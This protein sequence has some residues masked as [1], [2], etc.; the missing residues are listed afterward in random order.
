[1]P[2]LST[3]ISITLIV[4]GFSPKVPSKNFSELYNNLGGRSKGITPPKDTVRPIHAFEVRPLAGVAQ[5]PVIMHSKVSVPG[6]SA[7][8][9]QGA[10]ARPV[11]P[12]DVLLQRDRPAVPFHFALQR[13][14]GQ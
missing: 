2:F 3:I 7:L 10:A 5:V 9:Q 6:L 11:M 13:A 4:I 8:E 12:A 14:R 1:M